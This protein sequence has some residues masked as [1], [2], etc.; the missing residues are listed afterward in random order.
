MID[1]NA[2]FDS[3]ITGIERAEDH[4]LIQFYI[5]RDDGLGKRLKDAMIAAARRGVRVYFLFDEIGSI[6]LPEQYLADLREAGVEASK[7]NT[8]QGRRNRFQ[9]NFRNHRKTVVVDGLETWV[10]GHNVGDEYLGLDPEIGPWRDTHVHIVGPSALQ[11]QAD[12]VVDWNWA[13]DNLL[14]LSWTPQPAADADVMA[15]VLPLSPTDRVEKAQLFFVHA[16]NLARER[17]WIAT[18]YFVP[19]PAITTALRLAALSGVDVRVIVPEKSDNPVV[20][21]ATLWHIERLDRVG[22]KFYRY[23]EGF[24]HQKVFL[25]DDA[26]ATVGSTNFDNR[27][28]RL[29]FEVNALI[30]DVDFAS[31]MEAMLL[32]DMERSL[33]MDPAEV[34]EASLLKRLAISVSRLTSPLL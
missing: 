17:I 3:I 31:Q 2:T 4:V 14:E 24:M 21:L 28:F 13:T 5:V 25:I 27:S 7:F 23:N 10:G 19:D 9:L 22:I 33:P 32:E 26:V 6:G 15:M 11:A 1:G 30:Y 16:L 12:F 18:P 29:Q 8:T 20:D 34:R